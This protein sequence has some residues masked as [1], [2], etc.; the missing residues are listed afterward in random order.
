[1]TWGIRKAGPV[2]RHNAQW[3][4][5]GTWANQTGRLSLH[6]H[7]RDREEMARGTPTAKK[8]RPDRQERDQRDLG[9]RP[10][11]RTYG[12]VA[13][14]G[15]LILSAALLMSAAALGTALMILILAGL[16]VFVT[17]GRKRA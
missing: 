11:R 17:T 15:A 16:A 10:P 8:R 6:E 7:K 4:G 9:R 3:R 1:M 2:T 5:G 12:G 14:A 13:A